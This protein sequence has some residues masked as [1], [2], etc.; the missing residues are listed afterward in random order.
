[1]DDAI[2]LTA[3]VFLSVAAVAVLLHY[4]RQIR[5]AIENFTDNFPRG[6][7]PPTHP[8]PAKD[9]SLLTARP[10]KQ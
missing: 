9:S 6:G 7:P 8:S 3:R 2:V 10:R 4:H 1:M 5:E